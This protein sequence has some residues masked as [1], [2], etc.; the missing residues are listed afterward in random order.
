MI[1]TKKKIIEVEEF[2]SI[3]C[4]IC[5]TRYENPIEIQGCYQVRKTGSYGSIFGDGTTIECDICQHCLKERLGHYLR[6]S[7][8]TGGDM[9]NEEHPSR[10]ATSEKAWDSFFY[11]EDATDDFTKGEQ[12]PPQE[13]EDLD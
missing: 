6:V 2:E 1:L 13:R 3:M 10:L 4:D 12:G 5:Q 11:P 8:H 9:T 7:V